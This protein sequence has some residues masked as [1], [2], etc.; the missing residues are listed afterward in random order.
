[1]AFR[2]RDAS[3]AA[4]V[5]LLLLALGARLPRAVL[6]RRRGVIRL[7]YPGRQITVAP[8]MSVLEASRANGIPHASV[9]G[10]G[11]GG[12][13][14][15]CRVRVGKGADQLAPTGTDEVK[16]LERVGVPPDVRLACQIRPTAA[17]EVTPLLPPSARAVDGFHRPDYLHGSEREIAI[18]F[19]DLRAFTKFS[20]SKLPYDVVFV[21]NQYFRVMGTAVESAGGRIDKFIG[22]GIMALFGVSVTRDMSGLCT[23]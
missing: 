1:M 3:L 19:A 23:R 13:C 18:L 6:A 11:G 4:P 17:L 10:G 16:V 7:T 8:G 12:R 5:A 15:T 2:V 22:D 20:Q 9:C 14:S 21:L